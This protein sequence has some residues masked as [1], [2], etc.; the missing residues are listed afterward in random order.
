[1]KSLPQET[2]L[3]L[4]ADHLKRSLTRI[5]FEIIEQNKE[6]D[7]IVIIGIKTR[8]ISLAKRIVK[9]IKELEGITIPVD[10]IDI[11]FYR[12]DAKVDKSK[13]PQLNIDIQDK[14]VIL[15]DDVLYTGRTIRAALVCLLNIARPQKIKLATLIDRGHRELPIR[16]DYV[17]KN[18]PTAK[19]ENIKV[20]LFE[21]DGKD[22]VVLFQS[23]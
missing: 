11:S 10:E 14:I 4:D 5:S 16:P 3:I 9:R 21:D 18:I 17:G 12:D 1:M 7:Q 22:E 13:A 15:V 23:K 8:G 20:Y 19:N 2:K 6:L